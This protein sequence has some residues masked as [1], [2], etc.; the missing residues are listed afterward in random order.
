MSVIDHHEQTEGS[1]RAAASH[2]SEEILVGTALGS[3]DMLFD[4]RAQVQPS[5]FYFTGNQVIFEAACELADAG[6]PVDPTS[7]SVALADKGLIEVAGGKARLDDLWLRANQPLT[8]LYYAG[9]VAEKAGIRKLA[10]IHQQGMEL[11]RPGSGYSLEEALDKVRGDLSDLTEERIAHEIVNVSQSMEQ[12]FAH[13]EELALSDGGV[14]GVPTGFPELDDMTSGLQPGQMVIVAAR[15]AVGKALALDTPLPTPSGWTTMGEVQVGDLL[16]G[17]DGHP[18]AVVAATD[19]MTDRPCFSV[20]FNDGSVIVADGEHQWNTLIGGDP[21]TLRTRTTA[22]IASTIDHCHT[23]PAAAPLTGTPVE[24]PV[25]MYDLGVAAATASG[26]RIP[27]VC[28]RAS[29]EERRALLAGLLDTL[30]EVTAAGVVVR[31]TP[32]LADDVRGL[33]LGLGLMPSHLPLGGATTPDTTRSARSTAVCFRTHDPVFNRHDLAVAHKEM[34]RHWP[35][36]RPYRVITGVRPVH[37]VPVRCVQVD[38]ADALYLAGTSL[39]ATHNSTLALDFARSAAIHHSIP[40]V[41]FSMEMSVTELNMRTLAAEASVP[42]SEIKKGRLSEAHWSRISDASTKVMAAPLF[43]DDSPNTTPVEM[44]AKAARLKDRHGLGLIVVDYLQLMQS[45]GKVESRQQEVSTFSRQIKLLAK[46][47]EVPVVAL[48]QL[49]RG[50]EHRSDKTPM[51]S[52]LRESGSLEQ[53]ADI[54]LLISREE[55]FDPESTRVGEA[56]LI[57]AKQRQGPTGRILLSFQG[58]YSRF[59]GDAL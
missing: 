58:K 28:Q 29:I 21:A 5:D 42:L 30:G 31:T 47:L 57:V 53:D 49:N 11:V 38:A 50:S 12:T 27:E 40:T 25:P 8:C 14:T 19:T 45:S 13:M 24:F 17:A 16:L 15:P 37:S 55:V 52:D 43:W 34:A 7:V 1:P 9:V 4:I 51:L 33:I 3:P 39:V 48:S 20:T 6:K 56:D 44:R 59:R 26:G 35:T 54:V 23:I 32:G 10:A 22:Q 46:E 18:T 2:E 36:R 41:F